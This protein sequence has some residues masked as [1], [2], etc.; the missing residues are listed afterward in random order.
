[1]MPFDSIRL[2]CVWRALLW[3]SCAQR[4]RGIV[5]PAGGPEVLTS[6]YIAWGILGHEVS[7]WLF[8][9]SSSS[10][11]SSSPN[12]RSCV[13]VRGYTWESQALRGGDII[14]GVRKKNDEWCSALQLFLNSKLPLH[15]DVT[16]GEVL[17]QW[18][19]IAHVIQGQRLE[20]ND[21]KFPPI[22]L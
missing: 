9:H 18:Y 7:L 2:D 19:W 10:S 15:Q 17:I 14:L 21:L 8:W 11:S 1:M 16:E 13:Y 4:H 3:V 5:N 22:C 20:C 6:W 12:P